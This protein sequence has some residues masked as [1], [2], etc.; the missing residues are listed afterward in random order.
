MLR[1]NITDLGFRYFSIFGKDFTG[2]PF[3]KN[4]VE[5]LFDINL[6]DSQTKEASRTHN[7]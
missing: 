1:R 5:C 2:F 6:D 7:L 4:M 3:L